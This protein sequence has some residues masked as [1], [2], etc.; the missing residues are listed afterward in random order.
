MTRGRSG[1]V[2]DSLKGVAIRHVT[3]PLWA[4]REHP[5]LSSFF[6]EYLRT[7]FTPP[8]KLLELQ[9]ERLQRIL[10]FAFERCPYYTRRFRE[11][12][13][14]LDDIRRPAD[15]SRLPILTKDDIRQNL[16]DLIAR[17]IPPGSYED[18]FTGG[19]SGSPMSFKVSKLRWASRKAMTQRHDYWTGW[20]VGEKMGLLWGHPTELAHNGVWGRF[21]DAI[22]SR[23]ILLNTFDIRTAD[24]AKFAQDL[25]RQNVC[26]LKAY[27]R[28][29]LSFAEY[30][31][32][33][34]IKPPKLSAMIT[35]AECLSP[36]E[37]RF[38]EETL[39]CRTFDRYGCREF[40]VIASECESHDGMHLAAE[41]MVVEFVAGDRPA[42]P[43]EPGEIIVTDLLNEAMP[44]IRY[45]IGDVGS[46]MEGTCACG[47]GLPRMQMVAGRVTDFIHTPDGRWISGVAINT[48][49]IS[50][51]PGVRQAQIVQENCD[52]ILMRLVAIEDRREAAEQFLREKIPGMFGAKMR[53]SIKWEEN[54]APEASGK[55]RVTISACAAKHGFSGR[56]T[57]LDHNG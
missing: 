4:R 8:N 18:N 46:P 40:S 34:G 43:G 56:A 50:Q 37:R 14:S 35:T 20:R 13:V 29:L 57:A 30:L 49:L 15:L 38:V 28:S 31:S 21:R 23:D 6:R 44:F 12:G 54:I 5:G 41:T 16:P 26:F 24:L 45:K 2:F 47:R 32:S 53:Y 22:L 36:E 39:E 51:M 25:S 7:Q 17:G 48:Y 42:R 19:S 55:T 52:H 3:Y 1:S 11:A 27:S 10:R 33:N 9:S